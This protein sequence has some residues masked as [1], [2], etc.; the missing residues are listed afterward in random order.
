[1][2]LRRPLLQQ[3][4]RTW[5][6]HQGETLAYFAGCDYYRL[7]S[8]PEVL[9]AA[10]DAIDQYGLNVSASRWTTGNHHLYVELEKALS[11]F[12]G[13]D[14]IL[15]SNGFLTN[16]AVVQTI[17]N[18]FT[19]VFIDQR[20]H[21]SLKAAARAVQLPVASFA[22]RNANDLARQ[23]SGAS[24]P[25]VLTD[26]MFAHDGSL[27][28]LSEYD[29][30]LPAGGCL[31]VDDSHAAGVVG[32]QGRG[33]PE[34]HRLAPGRFVQTITLSKAFG[35]FGGAII[36]SEETCQ[37]ICDTSDVVAGA[38]PFPLPSAAAALVACRL[39]KEES[40][41]AALREN[42]RRLKTDSPIISVV[43]RDQGETEA[44]KAKLLAHGIYPSHIRYG[45][46][47]GFF[48]FAISSEHTRA[49]LEALASVLEKVR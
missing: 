36:A 30:I 20:A 24:K 12:F 34:S 32:A 22:H 44:L 49:Q 11:D 28:P 18:R 43:P 17:E 8:H 7:A 46:V 29:A 3:V 35:S 1:M 26:G 15:V 19:H 33:T 40:R 45:S 4:G 42:L 27:A 39:I 14:A 23:I 16:L 41:R 37:A 10:R 38:T 31:L 2:I 25:L 21:A 9:Q 6:R 48:R 47:E 13:A 5:V